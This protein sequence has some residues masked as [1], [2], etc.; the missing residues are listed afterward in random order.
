MSKFTKDRLDQLI[1]EGASVDTILNESLGTLQYDY[2]QKFINREELELTPNLIEARLRSSEYKKK[3]QQYKIKRGDLKKYSR[4]KLEDIK[5]AVD[6]SEYEAMAI[7]HIDANYFDNLPNLEI[8]QTRKRIWIER[9][10]EP[11]NTKDSFPIG[12]V[13]W[14]H[15]I[16][17]GFT[18]KEMLVISKE[19]GY[20]RQRKLDEQTSRKNYEKLQKDKENWEVNEEEEY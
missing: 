15:L 16:S 4:K 12:K 14:D 10:N 19:M 8:H 18:E 6:T 3:L 9:L 7:T 5:N 1:K 13:I 20:I 17:L 11:F 2:M